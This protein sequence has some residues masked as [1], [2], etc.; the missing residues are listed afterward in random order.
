MLTTNL[1]ETLFSTLPLQY[2][3]YLQYAGACIPV[4]PIVNNGSK[5]SPVGW[6]LIGM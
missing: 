5:P 1:D 4:G 2:V 3:I 6:I